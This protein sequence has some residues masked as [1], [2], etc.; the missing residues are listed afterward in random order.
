MNKFNEMLIDIVVKYK[1]QTLLFTI[2]ILVIFFSLILPELY[3]I[4]LLDK[5]MFIELDLIKLILLCLSI[6]FP[7]YFFD[8]M[9]LAF[10][11]SIKKV[12]RTNYLED[13]FITP[14]LALLSTVC[15]FNFF[16]LVFNL[17]INKFI[18]CIF[19][20]SYFTASYMGI[21][22]PIKKTELNDIDNE[23]K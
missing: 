1:K 20:F 14:A 22:K 16:M 6:S 18:I 19:L 15:F 2:F 9:L 21:S 5:T 12:E 11:Y 13:V 3:T 10:Y 23:K 8:V 4:Y 7:L 17:E